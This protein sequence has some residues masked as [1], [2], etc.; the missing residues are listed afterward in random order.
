MAQYA[1]EA[2]PRGIKVIIGGAGG[3]A[4]LPGYV[5]FGTV[6]SSFVQLTQS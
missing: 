2:A 4:H 3:A 1:K 6:L 5:Y